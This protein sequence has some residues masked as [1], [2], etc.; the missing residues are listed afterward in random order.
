[1]SVHAALVL[2]TNA[3]S[4]SDVDL[5]VIDLNKIQP[6]GTNMYLIQTSYFDDTVVKNGAGT[7]FTS[8]EIETAIKALTSPSTPK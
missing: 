1:M 8:G 5:Q 4:Y 3:T 2:D 7:P 6:V